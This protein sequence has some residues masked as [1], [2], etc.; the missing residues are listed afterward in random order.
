LQDF[1]WEIRAKNSNHTFSFEYLQSTAN[2]DN[3]NGKEI[4]TLIIN[5]SNANMFLSALFCQA[6]ATVT[7]SVVELYNTDGSHGAAR[8]AGIGAGIYKN[9]K[10]A[11]VGLECE[12]VI[13]PDKNIEPAYRD[14]YEK[15]LNVLKQ[16]LS[17]RNEN[18]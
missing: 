7:G 11:F 2:R 9:C 15:W 14:A 17:R 8:G 5:L 3:P 12:C 13:E 6:F 1:I 16:T 4:P 18:E 10:D